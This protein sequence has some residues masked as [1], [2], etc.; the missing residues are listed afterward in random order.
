MQGDDHLWMNQGG[1][2]FVERTASYFPKTS[3][4]AM[5]V[6]FFDWNNDGR[7]DFYTTDM[8]SDMFFAVDAKSERLKPAI[9][10]NLPALMDPSNNL[11][12]NAF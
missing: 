5:G 6:K 8:H 10:F 9:P 12:G 1:K 4:G 3:W 2:T 7:A 11:F